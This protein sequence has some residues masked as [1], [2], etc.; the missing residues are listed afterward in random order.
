[1][2]FSFIVKLNKSVWESDIWTN[3]SYIGHNKL[4]GYRYK[5]KKDCRKWI[6][7]SVLILALILIYVPVVKTQLYHEITG[8]PEAINST[9]DLS[10]YVLH[11]KQIILDG[12][13]EFFWKQFIISDQ[14]KNPR[15][16]RIIKVP[17]SWS[18]YRINGEGLSAGGYASYRIYLKKFS[19]NKD[20]TIFLSDFAGAYKVYI[21]G[22]LTAS[23]GILSKS[24]DKIFTTPKSQLYSVK[25]SKKDTYEVVIEVATTKF[26]GLYMAPSLYDYNNITR[27]M[28]F[29]SS[30]RMILLGIAFSAFII[31]IT[32]Y[33]FSVRR[34][35]YS[36][37]MPLLV[38]FVL[39]RMMLTT[40]LYNLWQPILFFNLS[41]E[42]TNE[43]MYLVSFVMKYLLIFPAQEQCG[44]PFCKKE[45]AGFLFF[46]CLLYLVFLIVPQGIYNDYLSVIIPALTFT[47]D[48]Y[49]AI[50]TLRWWDR[51][52]KYGIAVFLGGTLLVV[53][54][55][56]NS[57][58]L[59][60][61][62]YEN[63][64]LAMMIFFTIFLIIMVWVYSMRMVDLLDDFTV[65]T[66]RL[67]IA[68]KQIAMQKEYYGSLS[69]Q[70]NE[71][72]EIK[73]DINH[74]TGVM[75][76]LAE[77]GNL[78]K[79]RTFLREYCEQS[80][81]DQLPVFCEHTICNSIIGYYY[82]RAKEYGIAFES[83]CNMGLQSDIRDSDLCIVL[84]NALQNAV[85][86]C[87]QINLNRQRFVSIEMKAMKGQRL[88]KVTN[89]YQGE[90]KIK[91]GKYLSLKNSDSFGFGIQNM[92]KVIEAYGGYV[93]IDHS[94]GIFTF[95]VAI[96]E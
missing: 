17:D 16:D 62:I 38:L 28:N 48:I 75:L 39:L 74:F 27:E 72:R 22:K 6:L 9:M 10:D 86:A 45:K 12:E 68:Q 46:Y 49:I 19:Y 4:E 60:G 77:D 37:W 87:R 34:K 91:D 70:M 79:L 82:L 23:S 66:S 11:K 56:V 14:E 71:I 61:K 80:R 36:L 20:V 83:H 89:S 30:M 1:M 7:I 29:R 55:A 51:L 15:V 43:L 42:L 78:I 65:S 63:K 53:G 73:H 21:D 33:I 41:Y 57:Y 8:A 24:S 93:K 35:I 69:R 59:N 26:S 67:E 25:L 40:E 54:L 94:E 13:W 64:S 31:L 92:V 3:L 2:R 96:P 18:N 90:L 50:K 88:I 47:L 95:M 84:G 58:Y 76:Q 5:M 52:N 32:M 81:M 85:H 44:I